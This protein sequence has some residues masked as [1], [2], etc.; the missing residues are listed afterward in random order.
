MMLSDV[1]SIVIIYVLAPP[2]K[3]YIET[4][5]NPVDNYTVFVLVF[6][7]Q[8]PSG[9]W[10][11]RKLLNDWEVRSTFVPNVQGDWF[12]LNKSCAA[13]AVRVPGIC[14]LNT[15]GGGQ[16]KRKHPNILKQNSLSLRLLGSSKKQ[17]STFIIIDPCHDPLPP[18]SMLTWTIQPHTNKNDCFFGRPLQTQKPSTLILGVRG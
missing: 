9:C 3:N 8:S 13:P 6:V 17:P 4:M 14:C 7:A 11:P 2:K 18:K 15:E 5:R 1:K 16:K 10:Q 12:F